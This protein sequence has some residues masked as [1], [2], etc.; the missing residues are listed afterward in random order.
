MEVG[1]RPSI[2]GVKGLSG[3]EILVISGD[4]SGVFKILQAGVTLGKTGLMVMVLPGR[5]G[6]RGLTT[7]NTLVITPDGPPR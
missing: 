1:G 6:W 2:S 3:S 7:L 5:E 4:V